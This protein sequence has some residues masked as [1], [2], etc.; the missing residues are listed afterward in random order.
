MTKRGKFVCFEGCDRTGKSTQSAMLGSVLQATIKRFPDRTTQTGELLNNYLKGSNND[1]H[2][3]HLIFAAN[4]WE[5]INEIKKELLNG[6]DVIVDRYAYSGIAYSLAK[7][8]DHDWCMSTEK[9]LLKPDVILYFKLDPSVAAQR[10]EYGGE[11][12]E[13]L[14]F[15]TK[16]AQKF[17][18]LFDK[19]DDVVEIDASKSIEDIHH[20]VVNVVDQLKVE[21][22]HYIQ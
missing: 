16:V 7:G 21:Q 12:F 1:N 11:R 9:G 4:R 18:E 20:K 10:S 14:E 15:Q 22:F 2:S 6:N 5:S 13:N 17:E 19:L 3:I 8:L